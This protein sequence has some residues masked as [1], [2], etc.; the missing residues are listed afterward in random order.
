MGRQPCVLHELI[1]K[2]KEEVESLESLSGF[3]DVLREVLDR[4]YAVRG[5]ELYVM[6][7]YDD[8]WFK[9]HIKYENVNVTTIYSYEV[10]PKCRLWVVFI[11]PDLGSVFPPYSHVRAVFYRSTTTPPVIEVYETWTYEGGEW[12]GVWESGRDDLGLTNPMHGRYE[13]YYWW[14]ISKRRNT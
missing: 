12:H 11:T 9:H 3:R 8:R 2:A 4:G 5:R 14:L 1:Q 13:W 6:C 7:Y 10:H